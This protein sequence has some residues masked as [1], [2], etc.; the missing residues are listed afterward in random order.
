MIR[1]R[2]RSADTRMAPA[3]LV[4]AKAPVPGRVK[5]RLMPPC[6]PEQAAELAAAALADTL[7]T[8]ATA[9]GA[10]RLVL[11]LEGAPG[12]WVPAGFE[13][14]PQR[15]D[16]LAERLAAAFEDA[17]G[18]A[19]LVGM[20]TPQLTPALLEA[21]LQALEHAD[22]VF[23][24]AFDGGYWGIGLRKPDPEVFRGVPMSEARTAVAQRV[25]LAELGLRTAVLPPLVDVDTIEDARAVAAAA[26]RT[27]FARRLADM[28][29]AAA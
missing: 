16:G 1:D 2:A 23:G 4:I 20:D 19:F 27:R 25:R 7:A 17:D 28:E 18:P 3:L 5:T 8:A 22:A 9:R 10:G 14:V 29:R 12:P 13:A 21:G 24:A 26:P 11:A 15:G 6:T